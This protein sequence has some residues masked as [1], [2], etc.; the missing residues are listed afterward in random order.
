MKIKKTARLKTDENQ[1]LFIFTTLED[2]DDLAHLGLNILHNTFGDPN[3]ISDLLLLQFKE[4]VE[5]SKTTL[6][7]ERVL[8]QLNLVLKK[9]VL[10]G[11]LFI[12]LGVVEQLSV[13]GV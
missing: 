10:Q 6:A 13:C 2:L 8:V 1:L 5:G 4:R 7:E 3:N 11:L 9:G 12:K